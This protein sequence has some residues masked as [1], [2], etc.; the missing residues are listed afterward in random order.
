MTTVLITGGLGTIGSR[1]VPLLRQHGYDVKVLDNRIMRLHDYIRADVTSVSEAMEAFKRWDFDYILHL[2]G[3]AGR[4]NGELFARRTV[5]INVS[6]TLNVIQLCRE[7]GARLIFAS[8]SEVYGDVGETVMREDMVPRGQTNCYAI[9]KYRAEEYIRHFVE[10]YDLEAHT[11]S[12]SSCATA[13]ASTP[14]TSEAPSP[15]SS[16]TSCMTARSTCSEARPEAG[17]TSTTS[18]G[19]GTP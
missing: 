10:N 18:S 19:A 1:M 9:S 5:D 3:E 15:D 7:Y 12:A 13:P 11:S 8:I 17:A 6:G 4:E 16:T 2:A 14:P